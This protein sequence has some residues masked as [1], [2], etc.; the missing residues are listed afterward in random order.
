MTCELFY[1][2]VA[3]SMKRTVVILALLIINS[4]IS[5]CCGGVRGI[6]RFLFKAERFYKT[7]NS[8]MDRLD[9]IDKLIVLRFSVPRI[10][11]GN[12]PK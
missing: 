2:R 8:V 3:A 6:A 7:P 12:D 9:L 5:F 1:Q 10:V 11:I 4:L